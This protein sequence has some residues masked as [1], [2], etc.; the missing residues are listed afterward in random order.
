M[1]D[2]NENLEY[3]IQLGIKLC[4]DG[5]EWRDREGG[6]IIMKLVCENKR[7][8]LISKNII[9]KKLLKL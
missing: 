9:L 6:L 3:I 2:F 7:D 1:I 5:K 4:I 8:F